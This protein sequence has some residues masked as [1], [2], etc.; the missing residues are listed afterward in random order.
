MKIS[1]IYPQWKDRGLN[2]VSLFRV[3]PLG[4]IQLAMLTPAEWDVE[5]VDENTSTINFDA[6]TNLVGLSGMTALAP[7]AYEIADEYRRRG[8]KTVMGGVHASVLPDEVLAHVDSVVIG[9]GDEIWPQ[10]L[11]DFKTGRMERIYRA[12][13][14]KCLDFPMQRKVS[15]TFPIY[16]W[17]NMPLHRKLAYI[18]VSRGCPIGCEFCSVTQFNGK[19]LRAKSIPY[20]LR[21][22]EDERAVYGFDYLVLVD[23]NIVAYKRFAKELFKAL[24][25][26]NLQWSS[27]TDVRIADSNIVDLACASGLKAVFL[28]LESIKSG[29]L[30]SGVAQS[31]SRWRCKYEDAIRRLHDNGVLIEASFIFGFDDDTEDSIRATVEWAI[32]HAIEVCQFSILTP[33]PGTKLYAEM[34]SEGRIF[35]HDWTRFSATQCVFKSSQWA[36]EALE[37]QFRRAY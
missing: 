18:Q 28:G 1:L 14:P 10:V 33:L 12:S 26:L 11:Q 36:P 34:E 16:P 29:T 7:R 6:P 2:S 30:K 31:K 27:Q 5:I 24:K 15:R 3:P 32:K 19:A 17:N 37:D 22:I 9:E 35:T 21:E 20:L 23:D 13:W 25:P 4:L 8:I